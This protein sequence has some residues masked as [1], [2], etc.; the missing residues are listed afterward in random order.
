M[1]QVIPVPIRREIAE[2]HQQ[3]ETLA[4]IA[5]ALQLSFSTCLAYS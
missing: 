2:R 3:G 1:R 5:E 4:E